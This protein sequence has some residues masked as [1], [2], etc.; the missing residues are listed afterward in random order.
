MKRINIGVIMFFSLLPAMAEA[1]NA[2]LPPPPPPPPPPVSGTGLT[3]KADSLLTDGNIIEALNQ[4]RKTLSPD[5]ADRKYLY[6]YACA[7]SI[8]G[9]T[10]SSFRYLCLA[11]KAKPDLSPLTDP[12]LLNLRETEKWNEFENELITEINAISNN[13][14]KDTEYAKALCELLSMDQYCFYEVG[15]AVRKLGPGSPVISA[16]RRLQAMINKQN[17]EK[18]E[19]LLASKGWPKVSQVGS[20]AAGAAFFILQHSNAEAQQKYIGMFREACTGKEGSWHQYALMFDRMRM[21]QNLPQKYGTHYILDNRATKENVLYPLEDAEKV[22]EWRSEIGLEPLQ[23]YLR[24]MNIVNT[25]AE[26]K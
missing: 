23:D 3:S 11:I 20:E 19:D 7:L 21:N 6:N 13:S 16:L 12:Y 14:I 9:E 26:K 2:M 10:D 5:K 1:Q 4:Y 24:N 17:L 8:A 25:P 18:L 15:I 22:D